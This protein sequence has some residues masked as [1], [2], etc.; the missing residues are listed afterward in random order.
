[1]KICNISA[2]PLS[3]Q[4]RTGE[5]CCSLDISGPD[6]PAIYATARTIAEAG[7]DPLPSYFLHRGDPGSKGSKMDP[8]VLSVAAWQ[9]VRFEDVQA[10]ALLGQGPQQYRKRHGGDHVI[11]GQFQRRRRPVERVRYFFGETPLG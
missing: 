10:S 8:G 4:I 11:G 3:R 5:P 2:P 7:P 9:P 1:M 6:L